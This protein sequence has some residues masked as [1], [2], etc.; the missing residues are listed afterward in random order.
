MLVNFSEYNIGISIYASWI[1]VGWSVFRISL[2]TPI[3]YFLYALGCFWFFIFPLVFFSHVRIL[4]VGGFKD[5]ECSTQI[6]IW[7]RWQIQTTF[8]TL[9]AAS[10]LA[11]IFILIIKDIVIVN[12]KCRTRNHMHAILNPIA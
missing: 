4:K 8:P 9:A 1:H 5:L 6:L 11:K 12:R 3:V 2:Y 7:H 10:C